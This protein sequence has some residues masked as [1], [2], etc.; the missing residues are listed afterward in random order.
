MLV[1]IVKYERVEERKV[2]I[3]DI[4]EFCEKVYELEKENE[5]FY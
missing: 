1:K 4:F 5:L 3:N 2:V